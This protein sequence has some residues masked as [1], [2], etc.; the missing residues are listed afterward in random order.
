MSR[1]QSGDIYPLLAT[2]KISTLTAIVRINTYADQ[3]NKR[4]NLYLLL[5]KTIHAKTGYKNTKL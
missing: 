5:A 2:E 3:E 4:D 1:P